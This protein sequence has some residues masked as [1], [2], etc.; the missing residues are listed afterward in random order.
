[1]SLLW[2]CQIYAIC[3]LSGCDYIDKHF[4][5]AELFDINPKLYLHFIPYPATEIMQA[6]ENI[7][8]GKQGGI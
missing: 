8:D 6:V 3:V 2:F 5:C 1:M 4:L 7:P